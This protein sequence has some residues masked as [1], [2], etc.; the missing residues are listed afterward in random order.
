MNII[1]LFMEKCK[2]KLKFNQ[3][4]DFKLIENLPNNRTIKTR[5]YLMTLVKKFQILSS[6]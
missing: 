1:N 2:K 5:Y 4:V 6:L 3:G